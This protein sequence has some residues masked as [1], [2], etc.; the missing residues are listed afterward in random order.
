MIQHNAKN[1]TAECKNDTT[2]YKMISLSVRSK[3]KGT[4]TLIPTWT[5]LLLG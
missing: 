3:Q 5:T 1:N 4:Q 2:K